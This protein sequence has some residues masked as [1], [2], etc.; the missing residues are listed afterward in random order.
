M[1][2]YKK[3][4]IIFVFVF[5]TVNANTT[6]IN[7]PILN[8]MMYVETHGDK[9]KEVVVFVHGLGDEASTIWEKVLKN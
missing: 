8:S 9:N 3:L 2:I 5:S 6:F 1:K 7:E 4:L